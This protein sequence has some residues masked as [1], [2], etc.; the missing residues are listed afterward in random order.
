MD[1]GDSNAI[2]IFQVIPAS[3]LC[4]NFGN[5]KKIPIAI[6]LTRYGEEVNCLK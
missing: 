3:K 5:F 2:F 6:P 1:G 4:R